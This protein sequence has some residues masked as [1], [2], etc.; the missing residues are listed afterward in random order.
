MVDG[1]GGH[2]AGS[3]ATLERQ[4]VVFVRRAIVEFEIFVLTAFVF[5][6][7]A[8]KCNGINIQSGGPWR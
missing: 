3:D 8:F 7:I 6:S 1:S 2:L 4:E 5:L